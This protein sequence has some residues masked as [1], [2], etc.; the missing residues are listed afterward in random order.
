MSA[1]RLTFLLL[2]GLFTQQTFAVNDTTIQLNEQQWQ[3]L[4]EGIDYTENYRDPGEKETSG[5]TPATYQNGFN[6]SDYKYIIYFLVLVLI[7]WL[8]VWIFKNFNPN[9]NLP[10]PVQVADP[11]GE[12]DENIHEVDIESL[13]KEAIAGK[14]YRLAMRLNF[15]IIIRLLSEKGKI[16]FAKE[17]TNWEYHSELRDRLLAD[18]FKEVIREFELFWYGE[19]PLTEFQYH[20]IAPCFEAMQKKL[21]AHE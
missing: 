5:K 17:K 15:L 8:T 12:L 6:L 11:V 14:E 1:F 2:L 4:K 20:Q 13:L 19:H 10:S 3:E 7:G 9:Q 21:T 16:I 18:Q